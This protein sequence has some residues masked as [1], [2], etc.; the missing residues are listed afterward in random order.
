MKKSKLKKNYL[1]TK[2]NNLNEIR[3]VGMGLQELRFFSI[4]LSK[5]NPKDE[6]TRVVRFFLSDF[7]E[8][9]ELGRLNMAHLKN[10]VDALLTKVVSIP[11][12]NGTGMIRFQIFKECKI[13]EHPEE[14]WYI[15]I[16]A[17]DRALPLMFGFKSHYF[18][19]ELWNALRLKSVN[20]L[21]MY[22]VLKQ[23][24]KAG[25]RILS[26]K[27]LKAL[28]GLEP[29]EY[30]RF[31]NFKD[32]VLD[33]CQEALAKH[34][35]I[36]F[37]YEP[38]GKKGR[39]GKVLQLKFTI[40]KNKDFKDPLLLEKFINLSKE[41]GEADADIPNKY[42]E[43]IN[44]LM[45]ACDDEFNRLQ[46]EELHNIMKEV[47]PDKLRDDMA[48]FEYIAFRYKKMDIQDRLNKGKKNEVKS[49]FGLLK[50]YVR[51]NMPL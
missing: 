32:R 38:Y 15:E 39:G 18:K 19:Y 35:D 2:R 36:S 24:E 47:V 23:Y 14:G 31:N 25:C 45:S 46:I 27:D 6:K 51:E 37:T 34:T 7:Q 26:V 10:A 17:H 41:A 1:V 12:E 20:Q 5:I 4:Y 29:E 16:D 43:R 22:E 42:D 3:P 28:L 8:I 48:C 49:R 50:Y 9:M 40:T 13:S 44:F 30:P 33:S 21:R 11:D